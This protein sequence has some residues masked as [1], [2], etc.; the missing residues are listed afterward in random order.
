MAHWKF[1][2]QN[3]IVFDSPTEWRHSRPSFNPQLS[4][5]WS[6]ACLLLMLP[7]NEFPYPIPV[8]KSLWVFVSFHRSNLDNL[9][10]QNSSSVIVTR[11]RHRHSLS[12]LLPRSR[13]L[14][15][16]IFFRFLLGI[17][18]YIIDQTISS[19]HH[20]DTSALQQTP[21]LTSTTTARI[22]HHAAVRTRHNAIVHV[23]LR[24]RKSRFHITYP[25]NHLLTHFTPRHRFW[26]HPSHPCPL[27]WPTTQ[28]SMLV[29]KSS[30]FLAVP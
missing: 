30:S 20:F 4:G 15:Y 13:R 12:I 11:L 14:H 27:S 3:Q 26:P 7:S 29:G 16:I 9:F 8:R 5:R 17:P 18:Y 19:R 10:F 23:H 22:F 21:T 28:S 6:F 1:K 2:T 24:S 25:S